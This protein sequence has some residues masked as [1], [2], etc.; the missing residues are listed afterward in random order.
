MKTYHLDHEERD[1]LRSYNEDEWTAVSNLEEE[2]EHY[3][4]QAIATIQ[5]DQS[6][7]IRL[8]PQDFE[9]IQKQAQAAGIS[10]QALIASIVHKFIVGHLVETNVSSL[11]PIS[12]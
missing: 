5:R 11:P 1:V 12:E 4:S 3:R 8:A 2:L 9:A 10:D 7:S 6:I